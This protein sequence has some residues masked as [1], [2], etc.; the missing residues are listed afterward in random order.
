MT[1]AFE[2]N[3]SFKDGAQY[4][5]DSTSL[6]MADACP[7]YYQYKMIFGWDNP[8]KSFHLTFG[9]QLIA[10]RRLNSLFRK[11]WRILG[12]IPNSASRVRGTAA[13]T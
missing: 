10:P 3:K 9:M 2:L 11:L 12:T 4:V 1:K 7:R 6:K 5:W 8:S 13:T